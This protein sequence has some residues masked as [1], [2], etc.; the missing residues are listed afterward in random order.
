MDEAVRLAVTIENAEQQRTPERRV[1]TTSQ[2]DITCYKCNQKGHLARQCRVRFTSNQGRVNTTNRKT[3][4]YNGGTNGRGRGRYTAAPRKWQSSSAQQGDSRCSYC[5]SPW[6]HRNQCPKL[7]NG[8]KA[9]FPKT[10]QIIGD[11]NQNGSA[12]R[13]PVPSHTNRGHNRKH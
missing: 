12:S 10:N 6:H 9:N 1:F 5:N 2:A 13:P 3:F 11:P 8:H 4:T 7:A